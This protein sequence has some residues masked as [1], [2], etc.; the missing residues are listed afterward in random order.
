M[1]DPT[2]SAIYARMFHNAHKIEL[3]G[4]SM[5]RDEVG[6]TAVAADQKNAKGGNLADDM[7]LELN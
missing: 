5:R 3:K 4:D 2:L 1:G 6:F 7:K